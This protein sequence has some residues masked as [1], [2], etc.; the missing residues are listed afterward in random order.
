MAKRFIKFKMAFMLIPIILL[1]G[2]IAFAD[3]GAVLKTNVKNGTVN[4][5]GYIYIYS[6]TDSVRVYYTADGTEPD[7]K[8]NVYTGN[9][10][11]M[12][13]RKIRLKAVGYING[14]KGNVYD[15]GEIVPENQDGLVFVK[16]RL[17]PDTYSPSETVKSDLEIININDEPKKVDIVLALY[18]GE[19][20]CGAKR[21]PYTLSSGKN[22]VVTTAD[23]PDNV[24]ADSLS[25]RVYIF[26]SLEGLNP[27]TDGYSA[28]ETNSVPS[29]LALPVRYLRSAAGVPFAR[30]ITV[31]AQETEGA[32]KTAK[33]YT[34]QKLSGKSNSEAKFKMLHDGENLYIFAKVTDKTVYSDANS[35]KKSDR[36]VLYFDGKDDNCAYYD[37]NDSYIVITSDKRCE[38][39]GAVKQDAVKFETSVGADGWTCEIS[40][41]LESLGID[42]NG[43]KNPGFDFEFIDYYKSADYSVS[44]IWRG[45]DRNVYSTASFGEMVLE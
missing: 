22:T 45:S 1:S 32:W 33:Y 16:N 35:V 14:E 13:G 39:S 5:G 26:N 25:A 4:Y 43:T 34:A 38:T 31:D 40:V 41:G 28:E 11:L 36:I 37:G 21:R 17:S 15:Y 24:S 44:H 10:I 9:G 42:I 2:M 30:G 23:F 18:D 8:S 3:G 27:Y 20:L 19:E 6:D 29:G 12:Q 7:D